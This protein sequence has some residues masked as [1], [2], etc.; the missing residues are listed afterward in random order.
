[1]SVPD[2][3]ARRQRLEVLAGFVG[4]FTLVAFVNAAGL[5]VT[6]RPSLLASVVLLAMLLLSWLTWRAWRRARPEAAQ[7]P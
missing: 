6:G 7:S 5:I 4:F 2:S 1:M 3:V